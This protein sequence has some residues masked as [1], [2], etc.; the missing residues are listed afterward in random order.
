[1]NKSQEE[2]FL[3]CQT[4]TRVQ[5]YIETGKMFPFRFLI[6]CAAFFSL[7]ERSGNISFLVQKTFPLPPRKPVLVNYLCLQKLSHASKSYIWTVE[8]DLKAWLTIVV[9]HTTLEH[10]WNLSLKKIQA[11]NCR[12][13]MHISIRHR[14]IS[15]EYWKCIV[16][17]VWKNLATI[18]WRFAVLLAACSKTRNI[19]KTTYQPLVLLPPGNFADFISQYSFHIT[20][21]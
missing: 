4:S 21:K 16:E 1:M 15:S 14:D 18:H 11:S 20:F 13:R 7:F 12:V 3:F 6:T 10:L 19:S 5:F 2:Y 8:K 9:R 17:T